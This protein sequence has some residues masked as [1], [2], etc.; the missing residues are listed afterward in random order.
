MQDK[1]LYQ[2]DT[3]IGHDRQFFVYE[4]SFDGISIPLHFH[5]YYE[6]EIMCNSNGTTE[7]NGEFMELSHGDVFFSTPIDYHNYTF[8]AKTEIYN[9]SF[10]R[11]VYERI[12]D[13]SEHPLKICHYTKLSEQQIKVIPHLFSALKNAPQ[14]NNE[15]SDSLIRAIISLLGKGS[16]KSPQSY[17]DKAANYIKEHFREDI[18]LKDIALFCNLSTDYVRRVFEKQ[19]GITPNDYI[20]KT[21]LKYASKLLKTT[22][23][24]ITEIALGCGF[25]SIASFNRS[26]KEYYGC[27]PSKYQ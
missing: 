8:S 23:L 2:K 20:K 4:K 15:F 21:R 22:D 10:S 12:F 1:L 11:E 3:F 24:S 26:F 19:K 9:L 16:V 13:A 7:F 18:T 25:Q 27:P 14:N 5:D 17:A 6:I